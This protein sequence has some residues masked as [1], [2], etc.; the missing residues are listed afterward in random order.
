MN[1]VVGVQFKT[2]KKMLYFENKL[3]DCKIR[4]FVL[5]KTTNG[6]ELGE[7]CKFFNID[8]ENVKQENILAALN[9][10]RKA[11]KEDLLK[12]DE[13]LKFEKK[14]FKIAKTLIKK[15]NLNMK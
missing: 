3:N 15:Q 9:I 7:V 4:D 5:C 12:N 10:L 1:E 13:N 2:T 11:N 6:I 14:A 8:D